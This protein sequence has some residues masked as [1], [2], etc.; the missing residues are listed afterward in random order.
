MTTIIDWPTSGRGFAVEQQDEGIEW[1]VEMSAARSGRI[2]TFALPG[3]RWTCDLQFPEENVQ[4]LAH[5]RQL[6]ALLARLKGGAARLRLPNLLTP[7][8]LGTL[9]GAPVVAASAA[10]GA[11]SVQVSGALAGQNLLRGPS[12]EIDTDA[13]GI[14]DNWWPYQNV[15]VGTP[16]WTTGGP[17][18]AWGSAQWI[19]ATALGATDSDRVGVAQ[20]NVPATAMAGRTI[21]F[22][23]YMTRYSGNF[24]GRLFVRFFDAGGSELAGSLLSS[25]FNVA[26]Y[27]AT[28]RPSLTGTAPAAAHT[29]A[30]YVWAQQGGGAAMQLGVDAAQLEIGALT[31]RSIDVTMLRGDRVQFGAGGQ[32]VMVAA[33]AIGNDAGAITF[34]FEPEL[35]AA[36]PA[37]TLLVWD[38]PTSLY[39]QRE[40]ALMMPSRR[41]RLP[42]FGLSL[43]ETWE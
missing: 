39:V 21:T 16:T 25:A 22:S 41:D 32:R 17:S 11:T 8:P 19:A 40:P 43:V 5:R 42:G 13:D 20:L 18:F 9:R 7:Q 12:F 10:A 36:V 2:T 33:D 37:G 6:D 3:A 38:R 23:V 15:S 28:V 30:V 31:E 1:N 27:P 14:A 4:N 35:R 24:F 34:S 26:A 29:C